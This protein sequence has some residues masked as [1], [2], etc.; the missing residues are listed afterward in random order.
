MYGFK[1]DK[2]A[3]FTKEKLFAPLL[4]QT[5][6]LIWSLGNNARFDVNIRAFEKVK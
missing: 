5:A 4:T 6:T 1:N 2:K 3:F